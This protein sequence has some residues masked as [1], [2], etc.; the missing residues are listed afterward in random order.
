M[1]CRLLLIYMR[2]DLLYCM[3]D[4]E[5]ARM[6]KYGESKRLKLWW[7]L[8]RTSLPVWDLENFRPMDFCWHACTYICNYMVHSK[9][10]L[11][12][13]CYLVLATW[14]ILSHLWPN[15]HIKYEC[16]CSY[17]TKSIPGTKQYSCHDRQVHRH[18]HWIFFSMIDGSEI[19]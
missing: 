9:R 19:H 1:Y 13:R 5:T 7:Q 10:M 11:H 6:R 4:R 18:Y 3:E 14:H 8:Y 2:C 17:L 12:E 16:I 15:V